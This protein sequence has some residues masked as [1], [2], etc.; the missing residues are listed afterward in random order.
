MAKVIFLFVMMTLLSACA[1]DPRPNISIPKYAPK[2]RVIKQPRVALVLGGGGARGF[3]HLG[4][5]QVLVEH[6]I[7]IDLIV[8]TS[9]GSIVGAQYADNP[10]IKSLT[11]SVVNTPN[12]AVLG[13]NIGHWRSGLISGYRMQNYLLKHM[14][15]KSFR[16]LKI[17]FIA[18]ATNFVNGR[19]I[20]IKSGPVAPA[21]NASAA[22]PGIFE[23]ITLYGHLLVD[24]GV[25]DPVAVDVARAYH[26]RVI[27]AVNIDSHP[28]PK[29]AHGVFKR[30]YRGFALLSNNFT[31]AMLYGSGVVVVH[32]H[33]QD[34][35]TLGKVDR[36]ALIQAGRQEALRKLPE[37]LKLL[38]R[39]S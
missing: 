24:G 28:D 4:V 21:V 36:P 31:S 5:I 14:R 33:M 6:H 27:I 26:P 30:M 7:P 18:V 8:G 32:P 1:M 25:S 34:V 3:A 16:D 19:R 10:E 29:I 11:Q 12:S 9:A 2:P 15:S 39:T 35:S 13:I 17:P 37:I 38:G 23:P 20:V 22:I